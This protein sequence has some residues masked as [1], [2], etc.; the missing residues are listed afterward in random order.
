MSSSNCIRWYQH[1]WRIIHKS[2]HPTLKQIQGW[3]TSI[4]TGKAYL[5][6]RNNID[7]FI[8]Q[9]LDVSLQLQ[10]FLYTFK[11]FLL[12]VIHNSRS[13]HSSHFVLFDFWFSF[14]LRLPILLI[15]A[16]VYYSQFG[17]KRQ[18]SL[19]SVKSIERML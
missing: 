4:K 9:T 11:W 15:L 7:W 1:Y 3:E 19:L 2:S 14:L 5:K 13:V 12:G 8:C 17:W 18:Y 6:F 16:L 10:L